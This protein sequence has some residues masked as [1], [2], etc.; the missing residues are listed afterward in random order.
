MPTVLCDSSTTKAMAFIA[1]ERP[2][3]A[4]AFYRDVLGLRLLEDTPFALVFDAFGT[5]LR[6]QK[7]HSVV[8]APYTSFG[9]EV[10]DIRATAQALAMEGVKGVRYSHFD[11]DELGIWLAPG[12]A[13]VFWFK[14]P[15]GNLLSLTQF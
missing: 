14:D 7:A 15:D 6:V 9:F 4:L 5:M 8:L 2:E 13:R 10:K 3:R 12:G 1:T 11:Q